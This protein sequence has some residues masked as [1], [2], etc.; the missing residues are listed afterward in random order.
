MPGHQF[1]CT[2]CAAI[3]P[4][5]R[6]ALARPEHMQTMPQF[7]VLHCKLCA[8]ED[9][10]EGPACVG[11]PTP[12]APPASSASAARASAAARSRCCWP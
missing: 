4:T 9:E 6:L 11:A 1:T 5:S 7:S 2:A 12:S 10:P 3:H 8:Y